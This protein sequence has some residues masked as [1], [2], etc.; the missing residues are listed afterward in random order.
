MQPGDLLE[1]SANFEDFQ[2]EFN[3]ELET[4]ISE[5]IQKF[6]QWFKDYYKIKVK[7]YNTFL[8]MVS[9]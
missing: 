1:T 9:N 8:E 2:N 3:F 5:G 4:D 6:V 7:N